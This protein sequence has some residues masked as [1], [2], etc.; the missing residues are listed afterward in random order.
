MVSA[1][2]RIRLC[3]AIMA[4]LLGGQVLTAAVPPPLTP[5][6]LAQKL[7]PAVLAKLERDAAAGDADA[8][9]EL[10]LACD[11]GSTG[12]VD[13][14]KAAE[15]Y[16]QAAA[17]G[18]M[19]AHLR[20]GMLLED[21]SA[22]RQSYAEARAHY[23]QAVAGGVAEANLRLGIL[24][25]EGWGVTR[26]PVAAE[27]AI[28]R[29]ATAGYQPA[30]LV[31]SDMYAVGIGVQRDPAKAIAWAEKVAAQKSP[32]GELRMGNLALRRGLPRGDFQ[33]AREWYQLSAEKEYSQGMLAIAGTFFRPGQS[34]A[35]HK[36]G[37]RWLQLAADNGSSAA[38]FYLGGFIASSNANGAEE[39]A[40]RWLQTAADHGEAAATEAL[41]LAQNGQSL[42]DAFRYVMTVPFMDRYVKRYDAEKAR[43]ARDPNGSYPP[44]PIKLVEPVYP[45]ALRLTKTQGDVLVDFVVDTTGRVRNAFVLKTAHPAFSDR[46]LEAVQRWVFMPGRKSGA[47]VSTHM[48]VPVYF[49][50]SQIKDG[51][52]R[53][54]PTAP[55]ALQ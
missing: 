53:I 49:R 22:G 32:E 45:P 37:F 21:G 51:G 1:M 12:S 36:L 28:E 20:L 52:R 10:A 5:A 46:A 23:E 2:K 27:A 41:D 50:L 35:D 31:L 30:Q 8:Q 17:S 11:E 3:A 19:V 16:V 43:A 14:K 7:D 33:L 54:D 13:R 42:R 25:L 40:R 18:V 39:A 34:D 24:H 29:A 38:A 55:A 47:V 9:L 4:I 26:D 15:W 48:Q 6:P 44:M